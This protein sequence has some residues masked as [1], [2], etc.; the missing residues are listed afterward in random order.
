MLILRG[1]RERDLSKGTMIKK[2]SEKEPAWDLC[3]SAKRGFEFIWITDLICHQP[4]FI[5]CLTVQHSVGITTAACVSRGSSQLNL[6][7]SIHSMPVHPP[8]SIINAFPVSFLFSNCIISVF[9]VTYCE[10][11]KV[12]ITIAY[13]V[14]VLLFIFNNWFLKLISQEHRADIQMSSFIK[15]RY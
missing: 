9:R 6:R 15:N 2:N 1:R 4:I 8:H 13:L 3:S 5:S 12:A 10:T 7:L 14:P 11:N